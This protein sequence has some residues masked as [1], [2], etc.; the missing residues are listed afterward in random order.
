MSVCIIFHLLFLPTQL[1]MCNFCAVLYSFTVSRKQ[2]E[3]TVCQ[4]QGKCSLNILASG[5][6][7]LYK[8]PER[9]FEIKGKIGFNVY[10]EFY[11][12]VIFVC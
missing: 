4:R 3:N 1:H 6:F 2:G 11:S 7:W 5:I 10:M 9:I 12:A 8:V